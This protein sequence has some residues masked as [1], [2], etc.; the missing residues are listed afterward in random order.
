MIGSVQML[1][2][3]LILNLLDQENKTA[4][5]FLIVETASS[6]IQNDSFIAM[7][8]DFI[9]TIRL[10]RPIHQCKTICQQFL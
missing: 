2:K 4:E 10:V 3:F 7:T 5:T 6:V 9:G 1:K 8:V